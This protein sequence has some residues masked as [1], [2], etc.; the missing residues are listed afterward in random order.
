MFNG[1]FYF[2]E[3]PLA[4]FIQAGLG[5]TYIDSNVTDGPPS[6]GCWWDFWWGYVCSNFYST[7]S[8]T[9]FA[10][11][12]GAGVRYDMVGNMFVKGS[13]TYTWVD[14]GA[15]V[16]QTFGQFRLELGWRL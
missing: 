8:S 9:D 14:S 15:K 10:Y 6:T 1:I 3:K 2:T 7:Y 16:D 5:W 11:G 12:V 4:P 13:Y